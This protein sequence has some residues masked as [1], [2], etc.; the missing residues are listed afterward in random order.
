MEEHDLVSEL[1]IA[2][3]FFLLGRG[4]LFLAFIDQAQS[5]LQTPPNHT[6]EHCKFEE[7]FLHMYIPLLLLFCYGGWKNTLKRGETIKKW[8]EKYKHEKRKRKL[9]KI[10]LILPK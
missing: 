9:K 7:K 1:I 2:K 8:E 6:I 4:E 5:L 10:V 3:D